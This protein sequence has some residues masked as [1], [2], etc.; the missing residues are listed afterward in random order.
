MVG[1]VGHPYQLSQVES[2]AQL[3]LQ[4]TSGKTATLYA[5]Y[6]TAPMYPLPFFQVFGEKVHCSTMLYPSDLC[7]FT[8]ACKCLDPSLPPL[9]F[10]V[11]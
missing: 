11:R 5:H 1:V 10:R 6:S 3:L 8:L 7:M 4:F 9:D 2:L